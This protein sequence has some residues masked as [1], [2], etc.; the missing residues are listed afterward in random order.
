M[1]FYSEDEAFEYWLDMYEYEGKYEGT[2]R[3]FDDQLDMFNDWLEHDVCIVE[4]NRNL[5]D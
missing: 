3:N 2:G 5:Q 4:P 1:R